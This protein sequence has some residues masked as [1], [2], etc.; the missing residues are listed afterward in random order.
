MR[1]T[2]P[3]EIERSAIQN[4]NWTH[5]LACHVLQNDNGMFN[6]ASGVFD[7]IF[8]IHINI[9]FLRGPILDGDGGGGGGSAC[10]MATIPFVHVTCSCV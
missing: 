9:N 10:V 7:D 2:V 3:T 4:G 5:I 1:N 8:Y 6:S